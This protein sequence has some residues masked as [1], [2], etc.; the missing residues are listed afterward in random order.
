M[1]ARI[2][3]VHDNPVFSE[4]VTALQAAGYDVKSFAGSMEA[5]DALEATE[6]L[7]LLITRA[8][9]PEGTPNGVSLARMARM[10]KPGIRVLFVA[11]AENQEYTEGVGEF[12]PLPVTGSEIL[13][14]VK[15]MLAEDAA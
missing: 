7:E 12:L 1:P 3:V 11:L 13:A 6:R 9:F 14:T 15:R 8:A 2:V 4:C 5:L 10:K